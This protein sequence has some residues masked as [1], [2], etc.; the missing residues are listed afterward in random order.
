MLLL[1]SILGCA[2]S[3]VI[4]SYATLSNAASKNYTA[5][6]KIDVTAENSSIARDKGMKEAYRSAF[7]AIAA[8]TTNEEGLNRLSQLTDEQLIN[9]IKEATVVSEKSSD[10]RYM[11][12]LRIT[13]NNDLLKKFMQEQEINYYVTSSSNILVIPVFREYPEDKPLLWEKE[14]L[15]RTTWEDNAVTYSSNT[16]VSIPH[17][18]INSIF[19]DGPQALSINGKALDRISQHMGTQNIYILDAMYNGIEGLK[20][21]IIPYSSGHPQTINIKGSRSP[22]LFS[23][24]QPEIVKAI[25]AT[26]QKQKFNTSNQKNELTILYDYNKLSDWINTEK[27]IKEINLVNDVT[28]VA[29]GKGKIQ[30]QLNY[31]GNLEDL[32]TALREKGLILNDYNNFYTL[33]TAGQ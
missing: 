16:Y 3:L 32:K 18:S 1:K 20:I 2:L 17:D 21:Q 12:T 27:K 26:I 29:S 31:L 13:V 24:A 14:N 28:T 19:I 33:E 23:L 25:D 8:K 4:I 15:W 10:V 7:M 11:A 30:L 6:V 9:F 5:E 22:E